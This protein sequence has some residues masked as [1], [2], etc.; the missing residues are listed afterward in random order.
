MSCV[1][2]MWQSEPTFDWSQ[3]E[4]PPQAI[5]YSP[6]S[7]CDPSIQRV[8]ANDLRALLHGPTLNTGAR[9]CRAATTAPGHPVDEM[10]PVPSATATQD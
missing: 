3:V 2:F 6:L 1:H 8:V 9:F 7:N 10:T 4:A 5:S